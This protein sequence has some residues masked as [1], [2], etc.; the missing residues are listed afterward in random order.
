MEQ[1]QWWPIVGYEGSYYINL[2]GQVCNS[3]GH[4]IK[5]IASKDGWRVEL[6]KY[7]QRERLLIEQLVKSSINGVFK[8]GI[9]DENA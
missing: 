3:E 6:R 8:E 1:K 5:P 9:Q 4:L 2:E 7:G